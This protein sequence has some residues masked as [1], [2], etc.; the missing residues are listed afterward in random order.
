MLLGLFDGLEL[1]VGLVG[2]VVT[3]LLVHLL[4]LEI[5]KTTINFLIMALFWYG[6]VPLMTTYY[7]L[8]SPG[9]WDGM[10]ILNPLL[11]F[12]FQTVI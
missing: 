4:L 9:Y 5:E 7:L 6:G 8:I 12:Y 11:G 10:N 3:A 1:Q 2:R